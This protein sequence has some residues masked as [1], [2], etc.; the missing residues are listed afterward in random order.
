MA[1]FRCKLFVQRDNSWKEKGVGNLHLKPCS[2]KT[3]L[4][5]R[6]DTSL[7]KPSTTCFLCRHFPASKTFLIWHFSGGFTDCLSEFFRV[8]LPGSSFSENLIFSIIVP[9]S[10][11]FNCHGGLQLR[12]R[13]SH[14]WNSS[15]QWLCVICVKCRA[16]SCAFAL[17][18]KFVLGF[19]SPSYRRRNT[20][21]RTFQSYLRDTT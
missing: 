4:L 13:G 10:G 16:T 12:L 17:F 8:F 6:A 7:G 5:I 19:V 2:G 15:S 21:R 9:G 11:C 14:A 3:Q 20:T 1:V 18:R